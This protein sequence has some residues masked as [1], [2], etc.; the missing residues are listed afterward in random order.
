MTDRSQADK[1]RTQQWWALGLAGFGLLLFYP[2]EAHANAGTPLMWTSAFYLVLGNALIGVGEGLLIAQ[3]F[4]TRKKMTVPVMILANYFSAWVGYIGLIAFKNHFLDLN[5]YTAWQFIL[6]LTLATC[7]VSMI[8]EWPFIM[9]CMRKHLQ[10]GKQSAQA[11]ALA[12]GASYL[13]IIP[14][15]LMASGTSLYTRTTLDSDLAGRVT[16]AGH[17]YFISGEDGDVYRITLG[18][19]QPEYVF[20]LNSTDENDR[21][22]VRRS[23]GKD[24][25]DLFAR[26][27]T[28]ERDN[29]QLVSVQEGLSGIAA[30]EPQ[31]QR[32]GGKVRDNWA[33]FGPATD[34]RQLD[35]PKWWFR[36]SLWAGEGLT[37]GSK[38]RRVHLALETPFVRWPVRNA[39]VLPG[40]VV[41]FQL[42]QQ[43]CLFELES[44]RVGLLAMGRGPV[45]V[46]GGTDTVTCGTST[47]GKKA[48][49]RQM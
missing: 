20:D 28:D 26:L 32:D 34:L 30:P 6:L 38:R 31:R 40:D 42:G 23:T 3:V 18:D 24:G 17:V 25:W 14:I 8:L 11:T 4:G 37:A 48:S 27:E 10:W 36:V 29:P 35:E 22:F 47:T 7:V 9:F 46:L 41:V 21:L 19:A 13:F 45:V 33:Q 43:I 16:I 5:L 2:V 1:M 12:Q 15:F 44:K 49:I 39:T